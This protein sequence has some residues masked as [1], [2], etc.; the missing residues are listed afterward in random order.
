MTSK[1]KKKK[2]RKRIQ[3]NWV[4]RRVWPR[5]RTKHRHTKQSWSKVKEGN[6]NKANQWSERDQSGQTIQQLNKKYQKGI[7]QPNM[8]W[9]KLRQGI[10]TEK[11]NKTWPKLRLGV[12]VRIERNRTWL[13]KRHSKNRQINKADLK[14]LITPNLA[15]PKLRQGM[16]EENIKNKTWRKQSQPKETHIS[17]IF[18]TRKKSWIPAKARHL[19]EHLYHKT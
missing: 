11:R 14:R 8:T 6:K 16:I 12:I 13:K 10:I 18:K 17:K 7:I 19:K 5:I 9:P 15:W 2:K 4:W 3:Q 1:E